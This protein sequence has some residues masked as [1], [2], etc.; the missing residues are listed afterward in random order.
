M[1]PNDDS[2]D[3]DKVISAN[4]TVNDYIFQLLLER[5]ET[6]DAFL[7]LDTHRIPLYK[8]LCL[9]AFDVEID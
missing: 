4:V 5:Y 3:G 9:E 7:P 2:R 1:F 8:V 6:I